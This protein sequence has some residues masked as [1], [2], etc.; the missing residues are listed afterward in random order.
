MRRILFLSF[1][2]FVVQGHAS[3]SGTKGL[4]IA[5]E[6]DKRYSGYI[7]S[8]AKMKMVLISKA[9]DQ[10]IRELRVQMFETVADDG[11]GDKSLII[12]DSPRDVRG[13]ALLTWSYKEKNDMQ[14]LYLPALRK[15][16]T[17]ASN[18]KSGSFM[19]SEFSFEDMTPQEVEKYSY[20]YLK[21]EPCSEFTCF[22]FERYPVDSNSGYTKQVVRMDNQAYRIQKIDFYDRKNSLFKTL[23]VS[24]YSLYKDRFWRASKMEM[25]NHETGK[26]TELYWDQYEFGTGLS[27]SDFTNNS[28]MRAR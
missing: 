10:N 17:I 13:T 22:V 12:F 21:D 4:E 24:G 19:G 27:D 16:K 14:W 18:N 11:A 7:D 15:V 25:V 1:F 2:L 5:Q 6:A 9:G 28:L 3:D 26:R 23:S 20:N 8:S